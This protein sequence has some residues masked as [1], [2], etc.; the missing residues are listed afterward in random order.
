VRLP[1]P[2]AGLSRDLFLGAGAALLP[3]WATTM[4]ERG[5]LQRARDRAAARMMRGLAPLFRVA[6]SDGVAAR[7]C[8]RVG[9]APQSLAQWPQP[10]RHG[11]ENGGP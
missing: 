10:L 4:L 5:P 8:L 3:A 11:N 9:V 2:V 6:L 1:V 7:A